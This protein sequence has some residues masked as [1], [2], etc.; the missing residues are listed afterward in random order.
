MIMSAPLIKLPAETVIQRLLVDIK[1]SVEI[2]PLFQILCNTISISP[3]FHALYWGKVIEDPSKCEMLCRESAFPIPFTITSALNNLKVEWT[4]TN[5]RDREVWDSQSAQD[6]YPTSPQR[7]KSDFLLWKM[8]T[9]IPKCH[10]LPWHNWSYILTAPVVEMLSF[11]QLPSSLSTTIFTAIIEFISSRKG[12][13]GALGAKTF[14]YGDGAEEGRFLIMVG[15]ESI[16]AHEG[17][18]SGEGFAKLPGWVWEKVE[19]HHVRWERVLPGED[20][21]VAKL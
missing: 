17:A 3:G 9:Q 7:Q 13:S 10:Y 2:K 11:S 5:E 15:W 20:G 8:S 18:R 6:A 4:S 12:C 19:M 1:P 14:Q 21:G 16:A